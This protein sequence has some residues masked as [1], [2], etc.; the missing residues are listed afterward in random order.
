VLTAVHAYTDPPSEHDPRTPSQRR[1]AALVRISEVALAHIGEDRR[2]AAQVTVVVD[3]ETLTT[4]GP[5]RRDGG[6]TGP[7]H[8]RDIDRLLCDCDVSRVVTGP[9]GLPLDAGRSRR[10]AP[11]WIRR[12]ITVRDGGCRFPGCDRP[13]GWCQAHHVTRWIDGGRTS[14]TNLV[15]LCDRHHHVV[16]LP[17]W[18]LQF[19]GRDLT[20]LR[21]DG[22]ELREHA[23]PV[24]AGRAD[25][26]DPLG[27]RR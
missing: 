6:F 10:T 19:D 5:G 9:G 23:R 12:A 20:V 22:T 25:A 11:R 4:G 1:A 2:P 24:G 15:L 17:G 8:P 18:L 7:I 13:P 3:W 21:P 16:H 14:V 27:S 26:P